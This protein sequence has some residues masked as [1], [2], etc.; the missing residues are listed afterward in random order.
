MKTVLILLVL[1]A[2]VFSLAAKEIHVRGY[3]R[4]DGTHVKSYTRSSP[5]KGTS[6]RRTAES[7]SKSESEP[8]SKNKAK[9]RSK[10]GKLYIAHC[11]DPGT[12]CYYTFKVYNPNPRKFPVG[13]KKA[14]YSR[15]GGKC[16]HCGQHKNIKDMHAD[17]VIPYSKGGKTTESNL[18]LLCKDCNLRK[19]NRYSH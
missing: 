9:S 10:A 18:Q 4:K 15:Q 3:T 1:L 7:K 11:D 13:M 5:S 17:H 16:R 2:S 8:E 12:K 6:R 14:Q 19:G